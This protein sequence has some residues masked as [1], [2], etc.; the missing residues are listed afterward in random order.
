MQKANIECEDSERNIWRK[1]QNVARGRWGHARRLGNVQN[2]HSTCEQS[3]RWG[4]D[5]AFTVDCSVEA[6]RAA[7]N[8]LL[9]PDT[10]SNQLI[11]CSL[12]ECST[13]L[14]ASFEPASRKGPSVAVLN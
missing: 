14:P 3:E 2:R 4:L 12:R 8:S 9:R 1:R 5:F 6:G 13:H 11:L 7:R 10:P